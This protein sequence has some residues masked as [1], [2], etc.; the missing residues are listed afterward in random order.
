MTRK[1]TA[2]IMEILKTAYPQF[3]TGPSA[4]DM[5]QTLLLWTEMFAGDDA[6]LVAAAVKAFIAA[7]TKG[8]PPHIGAIK[9]AMYQLVSSGGLDSG[10]AW[11]LVRKAA[12][13]SAYESEK[14]FRRLPGAVQRIVGSPGQLYEWS[15]MDSETFNSVVA[16]NFQRV[17]RVRQEHSRQTALLPPNVK[18]VLQSLSPAF[19]WDQPR[20]S[21]NSTGGFAGE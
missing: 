9:N 19:D 10:Q 14:E 1:E 6:A 13:N 8:F 21:E 18:D 17:Y 12:S 20:L 16:S 4:P 5:R 3:Y 7:D 15:L 11:E 2:V